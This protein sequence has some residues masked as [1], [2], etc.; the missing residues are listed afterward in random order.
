MQH[1]TMPYNN[2]KDTS[3]SSQK[4][5][6]R[7][8]FV[9]IRKTGGTSIN[10]MFLSLAQCDPQELYQTLSSSFKASCNGRKYAGWNK[11]V[12]WNGDYHYAFSHHPR[13]SLLLPANTFSFSCFRDPVARVISLYNMLMTLKQENSAHPGMKEQGPWLGE[14]FDD[15]LD[16][17]PV[18][19]IANQLFMFSP[20]MNV[21]A[22]VMQ[23]RQLSYYFFTDIFDEGI[24]M[25][26]KKL[27]LKLE[28]AHLRSSVKKFDISEGSMSRLKE[29]LT[30]EYRFLKILR[31]EY[32]LRFRGELFSRLE[33]I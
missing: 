14:S 9:H 29:M 22:A 10:H 13:H 23:T 16:R 1:V 33:K 15:F 26:N 11:Q 19:E 24:I 17:A 28:P 27:N 20:D 3:V 12:I 31:K 30:D 32:A 25:L 5:P 18:T 4:Y 7:V 8:Y 2:R 21:E 6:D